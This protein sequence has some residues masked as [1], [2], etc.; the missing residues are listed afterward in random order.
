MPLIQQAAWFVWNHYAPRCLYL[1]ASFKSLQCRRLNQ[2]E[3]ILNV[4][5][6]MTSHTSYVNGINQVGVI[7]YQR[8]LRI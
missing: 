5:E 4:I 8:V 7:I 3:G 1:Q 2:D 6:M